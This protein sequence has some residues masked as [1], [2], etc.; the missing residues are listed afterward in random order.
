METPS[1][2]GLIIQIDLETRLVHLSGGIL[3]SN[4]G[5]RVTAVI[6]SLGICFAL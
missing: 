4:L 1:A 6:A 2:L 5:R 3:P